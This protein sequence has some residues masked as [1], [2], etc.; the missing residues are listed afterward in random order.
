MKREQQIEEEEEEE[1]IYT[2][3]INVYSKQ[4]GF[5]QKKNLM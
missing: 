1:Y 4:N 5:Q 2:N 3:N